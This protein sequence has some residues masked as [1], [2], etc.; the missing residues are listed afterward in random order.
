MYQKIGLLL[1]TLHLIFVIW[2]SW[3]IAVAPDSEASMAW[4]LFMFL[5]FPIIFG[6]EPCGALLHLI[7]APK[8][9]EWF[10][11]SGQLRD[12]YSFWLPAIY[13]GIFG[14]IWWYIL[15]VLVGKL[16]GRKSG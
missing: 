10:E 13:T 5:D 2:F 12:V 9:I 7:G 11:V 3:A 15:P 8:Y 1:S 16:F 4:V 14:S 6:I